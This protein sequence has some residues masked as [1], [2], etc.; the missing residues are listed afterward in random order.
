MKN[1]KI[2]A[3]F[4]VFFICNTSLFALGRAQRA[5]T[6]EPTIGGNEW[7]LCITGFDTS[8]LSE[9]SQLFVPAVKRSLVT[10]L[11]LISYR[12]RL[13][14]EYA[15]YEGSAWAVTRGAAARALAARQN[16]RSLLIFRGEP[17]W[18]LRQ[19]LTRLDAQIQSL[20]EELE[21]VENEMPLVNREPSFR[22]YHGNNDGIFPAP[23]ATGEEH[24][25]SQRHG[26]NG[27]LTGSIREHHNRYIVNLRLFASHARSFIYEDEIIFSP[28]DLDN[29]ISEISERLLE[30][31]SGSRPGAIAV[32]VQ[33][34]HALVLINRSFAGAGNVP[35]M[36]LPP[37]MV[38][39]YLSAD[40]YLSEVI[41]TEIVPGELVHIAASLRPVEYTEVAIFGAPGA[42]IY[43][44]SLFVGE[45]PLTL[46]LPLNHFEYISAQTLLGESARAVFTTPSYAHVS[47]AITMP[48][49]SLREPGR[50]MSARRAF[51]NAWGLTWL[52]GIATWIA[53]GHQLNTNDALIMANNAP[54]SFIDSGRRWNNAF[55]YLGGAVIGLVALDFF[56]IG[57]Y[58]FI[59][60]QEAPPILRPA[61]N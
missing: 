1:A 57:R 18:R 15:Y 39:V 24:R 9:R 44:G 55:M 25:F 59:A 27:F 48:M 8:A 47:S 28:E 13:P 31:L 60:S 4:A 35:T 42:H 12:V 21:R 37:G 5:E 41:E 36:E 49:L 34:P 56:L 19:N 50:V 33:P 61:G 40:N 3:F 45:A 10:R 46:R 29:A 54:Q 38:T 11:N 6:E 58:L 52:A 23:P 14:P 53:Y 20:R 26:A 2:L 51:Y 43:K 32:E 16:E 7:V 30:V 17:E 22:L